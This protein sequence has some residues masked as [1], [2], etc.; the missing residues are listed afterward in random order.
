MQSIQLRMVQYISI[1]VN[2]INLSE[3]ENLIW[4]INFFYNKSRIR[5]Q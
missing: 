1:Q 2:V 5:I 4:K 3:E